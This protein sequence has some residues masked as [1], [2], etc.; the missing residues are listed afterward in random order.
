[1]NQRKW[2]CRQRQGLLG[3]SF[4]SAMGILAAVELPLSWGIPLGIGQGAGLLIAVVSV[5]YCFYAGD[6]KPVRC[7]GSGYVCEKCELPVF[8]GSY[9]C[10]VCEICMPGYSHHSRWLNTC[11][12]QRNIYAYLSGLAGLAL[13]TACQATAEMSLSVLKALD[14]TIALRLKQRYSLHDHGYFF[15]LLLISAVLVAV[16]ISFASICS[17]S[18]HLF[19]AYFRWK[20]LRQSR[21]LPKPVLISQKS[22]ASVSS[23]FKLRSESFDSCAGESAIAKEYD[24]TAWSPLS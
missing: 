1:M 22:E 10:E 15:N 21:V 13:A 18:F 7:S 3:L 2:G 16:F 20:T 11:I 6:N 8:D 5:L 23:A 14:S 9:H 17:L 19:K 12:G 4:L 24:S